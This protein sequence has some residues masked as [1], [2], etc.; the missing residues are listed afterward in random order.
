LEKLK[1]LREQI[2]SP[3]S[4]VKSQAEAVA[5]IDGILVEMQGILDRMLE[6]ETFNEALEMLR[7]II[8]TQEEVNEE[9][10]QQ[11]KKSLRS[12]IE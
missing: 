2:A 12:L 4:A 11:Q 6:L 10:K 7:K 3:D 8:E 1:Q 5:Q 9:T